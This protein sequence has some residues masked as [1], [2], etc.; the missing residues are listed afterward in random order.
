MP[1]QSQHMFPRPFS[2][3]GGRYLNY[4]IPHC[5]SS[6][7]NNTRAW[8]VFSEF[9]TCYQNAGLHSSVST[10]CIALFIS[11]LCAKGLAPATITSYLS[12]IAYLHKITGHFDPTKSF[13]VEKLLVALGRHSQADVRMPISRPMLYKLVTLCS[14][15][16]HLPVVDLCSGYCS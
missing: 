4:S 1:P 3:R 11:F 12:T 5:R 7:T 13:L 10:P 14:I 9:Y 2:H 6:L 15:L 16:V 8:V